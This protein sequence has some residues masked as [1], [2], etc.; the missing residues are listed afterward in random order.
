MRPEQLEAL[1]NGFNDELEKI[2]FILPVATPVPVPGPAPINPLRLLTL[3]F[4]IGATL[5]ATPVAA[6][7]DLKSLAQAK[8][9]IKRKKPDSYFDM[10]MGD[11]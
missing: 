11:Y 10:F 4:R 3:P 2:A 6:A 7:K 5:V 9:W 1:C 8:G